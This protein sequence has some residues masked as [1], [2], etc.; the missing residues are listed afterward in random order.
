MIHLLRTCL[1]GL[2]TLFFTTYQ[3]L[4]A[5]TIS[6][7]D[8]LATFPIPQGV[9]APFCGQ[10]QGRLTVAGGCNFPNKPASDGGKKVFYDAIYQYQTDSNQW[11]LVG[12]LP[13]PLAYGCSI[14]TEKGLLCIGGN[15][16]QGASASVYLIQ[17]GKN[18][19]QIHSLPD[20]PTSIDNGAATRIG[21]SVYVT[22]GNQ[23]E[24]KQTLYR[25]NLKTPQKGW[26]RL[27]SYPGLPRLQP[28][29][30]A[31]GHRLILIGGYSFSPAKEVFLPTDLLAFDTRIQN[32]ETLTRLP[33]D[34]NSS[35]VGGVGFVHQHQLFLLGGVNGL[36][37]RQALEGKLGNNYLRH[38]ISWYQFNAKVAV[39]HLKSHRWKVLPELPRSNRAG[40]GLFQTADKLILTGGELKPGIRTP[41]TTIYQIRTSNF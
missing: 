19:I 13:Q 34:F 15:N 35:H 29:L 6:W 28:V 23:T 25:M 24:R 30:V 20:L 37:F 39:F 36:I 33:E 18:G 38:P 17:E 5:Q 1:V 11:T 22:G 14:Q 40:S 16:N 3:P 31:D 27:A 2:V 8:T 32:W 7:V 26:E 21:Q 4:R 9:S 41:Q 12:S 10:I